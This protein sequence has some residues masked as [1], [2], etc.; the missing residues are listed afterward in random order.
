MSPLRTSTRSVMCS[1]LITAQSCISSEMS[2]ITPSRQRRSI[3]SDAMS[4]PPETMCIWLS[5]WV[6]ECN[7]SSSH[8]D[9]IPFVAWRWK[10]DSFGDGYPTHPGVWIE[11]L[12]VR[13]TSLIHHLFLGR[14]GGARSFTTMRE[15]HHARGS[16]RQTSDLDS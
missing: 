12:C 14:I 6:P 5:K 7:G 2:T 13:S 8:W 15:L 1:G 10:Y 4:A 16:K 9:T 11:N 3:G